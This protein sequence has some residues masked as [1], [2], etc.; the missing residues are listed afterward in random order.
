MSEIFIGRLREMDGKAK[1]VLGAALKSTPAGGVVRSRFDL[2]TSSQAAIQNALN[3]SFSAAIALRFE[4]IADAICGIELTAGGQKLT[5]S[6]A[7]YL[8]ELEDKAGALLTA[9]APMSK[10]ANPPPN[11]AT[12]VPAAAPAPANTEAA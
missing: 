2:A 6:V 3:E 11:T 10:V 4:T 12:A 5:W 9:Q 1:A 8:D 7:G